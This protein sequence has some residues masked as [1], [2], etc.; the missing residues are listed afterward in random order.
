L[1]NLVLFD[2]ATRKTGRATAA[3]VTARMKGEAFS[4]FDT[5]AKAFLE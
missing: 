4:R 2:R 3:L 1:D 5:L